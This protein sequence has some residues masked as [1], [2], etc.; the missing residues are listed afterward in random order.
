M[1]PLWNLSKQFEQA[2]LLAKIPKVRKL[3]LAGWS[4]SSDTVLSHT[5]F[6]NLS[7]LHQLNMVRN[8]GVVFPRLPPSLQILNF[9]HCTPDRS[10]NQESNENLMSN[11]LPELTDL[12]LTEFTD[13]TLN[14]LSSLL[15]ASNGKLESLDIESCVQL[16]PKDI[17]TLLES[18]FLEKVT[19]LT[20]C[21]LSINDSTA[22]LVA[23]NL[24]RLK[25]IDLSQTRVT[26][27]GVKAL[28]LKPHSRLE[29]LVL[30]GC[31][32]DRD[33]I[34]FVL[35]HGITVDH[36]HSSKDLLRVGRIARYSF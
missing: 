1:T 2:A 5:D 9:W 27:I 19:H 18:N 35:A 12:V 16:E 20:L 26:G 31:L 22:E 23:Q 7:E 34:D 33:V 30:T 24:P 21:K 4:W 11:I 36:G 29:R 10:L 25:N 6:T 17:N 3:T 8:S 28:V 14:G 15:S 13:L 32:L